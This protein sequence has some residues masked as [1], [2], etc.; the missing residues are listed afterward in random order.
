MKPL[1]PIASL[2]SKSE[3]AQQKLAAGTWQHTML[4]KHLKSLHIAS[5]LMNKS[6]DETRNLAREDLQETLRGV[7]VMMRKAQ[8]AQA[9]FSRGTSHHT[10]QRNRVKALRTAVAL[11]KV[12]LGKRKA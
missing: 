10:L 5:A 4:R 9:K 11:V 6:A 1:G 2:I 3:K 7:T 8:K 12:E